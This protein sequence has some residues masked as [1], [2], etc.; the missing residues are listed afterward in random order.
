MAKQDKKTISLVVDRFETR[1]ERRRSKEDEWIEYEK[2]YHLQR[3]RTERE[4]ADIELGIKSDVKMPRE[5]VTI[6]TK[7]PRIMASMFGR[8]PIMKVLTDNE[9]LLEQAKNN[10]IMLENYF[11]KYLYVPTFFTLEQALKIG[12]GILALMWLFKKDGGEL[13]D[14]P[15]FEKVDLFN[16]Y[17]PETYLTVDSAPY[18]IRRVL[19]S[20]DHIK[21]MAEKGIYKNVDDITDKSFGNISDENDRLA[22]RLEIAGLSGGGQTISGLDTQDKEIKYVELLEHW[23]D[24]RVITIANRSV[25]LRD[26]ENEKGFKPFFAIKDY[27]QE[28]MFY[29]K[30]EIE[31]LADLPQ[32]AEDVKNLRVDILKRVAHPGALV[33]RKARIRNQD[34][35]IKPFQI[36]KTDDMEGYKEIQRPEVKR[37]IFDEEVVAEGNIEDTTGIYKYLKGGPAPRGET[38][39]T[40]AEMKESGSERINS[41]VNFNCKTFLTPLAEKTTRL[42]LAKLDT[43]KWFRYVTPEGKTAYKKMSKKDLAKDY[44]EFFTY[45]SNAFV[46]KS[47]SDITLQNN[48]MALYD[49]L[50]GSG[51]ANVYELNKFMLD[52][53]EIKGRDDILFKGFE[54]QL[55]ETLRKDE[56]LAQV[57]G[58]LASNPQVAQIVEAIMANPQVLG[59]IMAQMQG[60]QPAPEGMPP[61]EVPPEGGQVV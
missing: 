46:I 56:G 45:E 36:I 42:C 61:Q 31:I 29:A 14:R 51:N 54:T 5:L 3:D 49:R 53:F 1:K 25:V 33:S 19:K 60:Q 10:E 58:A 15:H 43:D 17:I 39:Y 34:L 38:A 47:L 48:F 28:N 59:K 44:R 41:M 30:G 20:L 6:E 50:V 35:I 37:S 27:P 16:F 32:Y 4:L 52:M 18:V 57:V 11:R 2:K 9:E 7:K 21:K 22:E 13:I 40:T 12:T 26:G 23:E 8:A 55:V 24:D